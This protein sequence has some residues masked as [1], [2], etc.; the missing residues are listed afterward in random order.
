MMFK[1]QI[2]HDNRKVFMNLDEFSEYHMVNGRNMAVLTDGNEQIEQE[3]R[4]RNEGDRY[5]GGVYRKQ[6][7]IYVH[8][9]DFG[10]LPAVGRALTL[11]KRTYV[12]TDAINEEG[13]YS[14]TLEANKT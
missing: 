5:G 10:P 4:Y 14:I 1:E 12:I 2:A 9:E 6:L 11:D 3:K 7:L 13:I 8:A